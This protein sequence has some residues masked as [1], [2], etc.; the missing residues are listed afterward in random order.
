MDHTTGSLSWVAQLQAYIN[1]SHPS[2]DNGKAAMQRKRLSDTVL[3]N[4]QSAEAWLSFLSNEEQL[5]SMAPPAAPSGK[6]TTTLYQLY[7]KATELVT[8]PRGSVADGAYLS[9][10]LGYV[11]NQWCVAPSCAH[12]CRVATTCVPA[13]ASVHPGAGPHVD[14]PHP[15]AE[16]HAAGLATRMMH[17]TH[18]RPCAT[19]QVCVHPKAK[20]SGQPCHFADMWS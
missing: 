13:H 5:A 10:W 4:P 17:V 8:R 1:A 12:A 11:R 7:H 6:K 19:S 3:D 20:S 14:S 9:I 2:L 16:P 18:L 15:N